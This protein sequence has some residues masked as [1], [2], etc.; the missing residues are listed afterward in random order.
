MVEQFL[1]YA[2]SIIQ[3]NKENKLMILPD[4]AAGHYGKYSD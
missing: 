4:Q 1:R 2:M 3:Y